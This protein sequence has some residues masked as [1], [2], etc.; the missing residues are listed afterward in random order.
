MICLL[1]ANL[2]SRSGSLI[3]L[4]GKR[5]KNQGE[6]C[7]DERK[8]KKKYRDV[9]YCND[10]RPRCDRWNWSQL[11]TKRLIMP[12]D[13]SRELKVEQKSHFPNN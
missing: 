13:I 12:L 11:P 7:F 1:A 2:N 9:I 6:K 10:C 5:E 4:A 3:H 8:V